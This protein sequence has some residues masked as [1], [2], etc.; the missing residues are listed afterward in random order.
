MYWTFALSQIILLSASHALSHG[1]LTDSFRNSHPDIFIRCTLQWGDGPWGTQLLSQ[2]CSISDCTRILSSFVS[3]ASESS[4][5]EACTSHQNPCPLGM[6][7]WF[8]LCR[9]PRTDMCMLSEY[10]CAKSL[11]LCLTPCD[12][13]DCSLCPRDSPGQNTGM[14]GHALLQ[15]IFLTRGSNL[16]L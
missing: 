7:W 15:E 6:S 5:D 4:K 13:V 16:H 1:F 3:K 11:R 2:A 14:G 9:G 12:P 10:K 8:D